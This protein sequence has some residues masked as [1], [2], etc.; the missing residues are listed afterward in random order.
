VQISELLCRKNFSQNWQTNSCYAISSLQGQDIVLY[1][2]EHFFGRLVADRLFKFEPSNVS[3][4]HCRLFLGTVKNEQGREE[5]T[6]FVQDSS[7]NGTYIQG[8]KLER[9]GKPMVLHPGDILSL[10]GP[11]ESGK[12]NS[13]PLFYSHRRQTSQLS[14]T[15]IASQ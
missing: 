10:V 8:Q 2:K 11:P 5:T 13:P 15:G 3:G 9:G 6:V 1:R 12:L 4:K 14:V 7:S